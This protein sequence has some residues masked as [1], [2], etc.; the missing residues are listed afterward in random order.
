AEEAAAAAAQARR[1]AEAEEL[2]AEVERRRR[3]VEA[4]RASRAAEQA[5]A[6]AD[7]QA[8]Q[9]GG[10][11]GSGSG[12]GGE[13]GP[14]AGEGGVQGGGGGT[15]ETGKGGA[16]WSLEDDDEDDNAHLN[17]GGEEAED[18]LDA[19]MRGNTSAVA[20][21]AKAAGS[22][23]G[24]GSAPLKQ[25]AT[26]PQQQA[27]SVKME[28]D[29]QAAA[30]AEEE[31]D[32]LDA[33]MSCAVL[34]KVVFATPGGPPAAAPSPAPPSAPSADHSPTPMHID[35]PSA[36]G[37]LSPLAV[38]VEATTP[39]VKQEPS[40]AAPT[41]PT[42]PTGNRIPVNSRLAVGSGRPGSGVMAV[43]G[44]SLGPGP[45]AGG[46][47]GQPSL[48]TSA[49]NDAAAS[50]NVGPA[51]KKKGVAG[52]GGGMRG[53]GRRRVVGRGASSG[54]D[55]GSEDEEESEEEDDAEW[56][57][58]VTSGKMTK[59]DKLGLTDHSRMNY[60]P[61]RKAFYTEVPELSRMTLEQV[62]TLR[63]EL[64]GIKVRGVDVPKPIKAWTQ[65]G[66]H[67]KVLEV[68]RKSGCTQP[69]PIQAQA[70][71]VIM[72]GR[73]CIGIAKTGSGKTLAFVLP[74]LRHA[75][76]Q[77]PLA[78]G[79]GP[80]GLIMAPT[81]EL[82]QQISK[83]VKKLAKLLDM[84]CTAVFGGSGVANQISEL[85]RGVE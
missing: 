45:R 82:V 27:A 53:S 6:A 33:F 35:P 29:G 69:L 28:E 39:T 15:D 42:A 17:Q 58:L 79:D 70:L 49:A 37:S 84:S 38:K 8:A 68:L 26:Q 11:G 64:D 30:A 75:K 34:P 44:R 65:A 77:P 7:S 20:A 4:W 43:G 1:A 40:A 16:G 22:A 61:F 85:K 59:G 78:V 36:P 50:T 54:S 14:G 25:E 47:A 52:T 18:P 19:F 62:A 60:A 73:D 9:G 76:D 12:T 10:G 21:D 5:A 57:R 3:R 41:G 74:L 67:S 32:P 72:S 80:I 63:K 46:G 66:L 51:A 23:Q 81:R 55:S 48:T 2:D 24:P 83:E 31:E 13:V 71:P 56:A